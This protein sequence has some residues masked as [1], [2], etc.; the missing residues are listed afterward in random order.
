[1]DTVEQVAEFMRSRGLLLVT[2]E[3]CT[4]GLIA[5]TLGDV[6]GAGKLLDCA[7]VAYSVDAKRRNL[8]VRD[9]TLRQYNLTSEEVAREM[10]QGALHGTRANLAISNTGVVDDT[11][12]RI[13][14]GT[15]CFAWVFRKPAANAESVGGAL[16]VFS[17]T[18]VFQGDRTAIRQASAHYALLRIPY[19]HARL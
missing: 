6:P 8:G 5:A 15:Q 7:F 17:E 1:M 18:R 19:Y 3:S 16:E 10:A 13:P 9:S 12:S 11:D 14:A 4:A 2:A